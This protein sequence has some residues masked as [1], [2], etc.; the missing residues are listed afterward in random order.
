MAKCLYGTVPGEQKSAVLNMMTP[1]S[2]LYNTA[3][4]SMADHV[5]IMDNPR[6]KSSG[7]RYESTM[8]LQVEHFYISDLPKDEPI[9]LRDLAKVNDQLILRLWAAS[10][11][12]LHP[13]IA[14][15]A[16]LVIPSDGIWPLARSPQGFSF[17][18]EPVFKA[19]SRGMKLEDHVY[20]TVPK[21]MHAPAYEREYAGMAAR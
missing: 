20:E 8:P 19:G 18:L 17:G 13:E 14:R 16:Y 3:I 6:I 11:N 4:E 21:R 2:E 10:Y 12:D 1:G 5:W 15:N 7:E 9:P